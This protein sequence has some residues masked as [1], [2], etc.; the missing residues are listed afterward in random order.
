VTDSANAKPHI[1]TAW[2][3]VLG[4]FA[5]LVVFALPSPDLAARERF[6]VTQ[7]LEVAPTLT[8]T[9]VLAQPKARWHADSRRFPQSGWLD[10]REIWRRVR[11]DDAEQALPGT[12]LVADLGFIMLREVDF[13]VVHDGRVVQSWHT[14]IDRTEASTMKRTGPSYAFPF[15][16][17]AE[18]TT[19]LYV[20]VANA[21]DFHGDLTVRRDVDH[22]TYTQR[23]LI[24]M[25]LLLGAAAAILLYNGLS[26]VLIRRPGDGLFLAL[27]G[28]LISTTGMLSGMLYSLLPAFLSSYRLGSILFNEAFLLAVIL[29][30]AFLRHY[31]ALDRNFPWLVRRC[32]IAQ[33]AALTAMIVIPFVPTQWGILIVSWA[34]IA[35]L[36]L[37]LYHFLRFAWIGKLRRLLLYFGLMQLTTIVSVA[38]IL[39]L[40]PSTPVL[41]NLYLVG[42]AWMGLFMTSEVA[43]RIRVLAD[44]YRRIVSS[45]QSDTKRHQL[46]A[47]LGDTFTEQLHASEIQVSILF[48]DIVSFSSL[49]QRREAHDVFTQLSQQLARIT[50]IVKRHGGSIDRSLGD[51]MVCF[52]GYDPP[53]SPAQHA[54]A[55]FQAAVEIQSYV[56]ERASTLRESAQSRQSDMLLPVRIGLHTDRV[57]IGNLGGDV[58]VDFSMVG[59][60][61]IFAHRLEAACSPFRILISK[62]ARDLLAAGAVAS[63]RLVPTHIAVKHQ[64]ELV[65]AYEFDPF[66]DSPQAL[67]VAERL[68]QAQAG[69]RRRIK[70]NAAPAADGFR[71]VSRYGEFDVLDYSAGGFRAFSSVFLGRNAMI[72]VELATVDA[73]LRKRLDEKLLADMTVEVRWSRRVEGGFEH[74]LRIVGGS[75]QQH[76]LRLRLLET[77]VAA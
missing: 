20:R 58:Q 66:L 53:T 52:F 45:L 55:A 7:L 22:H 44:G 4:L 30:F 6:P 73:T 36:V 59:Q 27:H 5:L 49:A 57:M 48:I 18:G 3:A 71:L 17:A 38:S 2:A 56:V 21:L 72:E 63:D 60:G 62:E 40:I 35:V 24:L 10:F 61:V 34:A 47:L 29:F 14:G 15:T 43:D 8:I 70:R 42:V 77:R 31:L 65:Q 46:N 54:L 51:G 13:Y 64:P 50:T 74:G 9:E 16:I 75:L 67:A 19:D 33:R 12:R 41:D 23:R 76:Q 37:A 68:Y 1:P 26:Y 25:G 32:R 11:L 39:G 28:I 69:I